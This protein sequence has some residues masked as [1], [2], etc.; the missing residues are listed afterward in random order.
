V[1]IRSHAAAHGL[2][3]SDTA[4]EHQQIKIGFVSELCQMPPETPANIV[5]YGR[6]AKDIVVAGSDWNR[7]L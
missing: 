6:I 1:T 5:T 3:Q 4:V 2:A 7:V